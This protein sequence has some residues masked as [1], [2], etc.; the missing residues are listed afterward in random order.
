MPQLFIFDAKEEMIYSNVLF[1]EVISRV[2][3]KKKFSFNNKP[4]PV[5][6]VSTA[7]KFEAS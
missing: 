5:Y 7:V 1:Q 4:E 3:R 2:D 6:S